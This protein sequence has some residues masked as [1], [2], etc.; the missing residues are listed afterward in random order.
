MPI[1]PGTKLGNYEIVEP[2]GVGGMGEVYRARDTKLGR[3]V[4]IK[5]L[6][7]DVARNTERLSRFEREAKLLAALNHPGIATLYGVEEREGKPFLVM[8]LVDGE[9]LG[10]R[11]VRGRAPVSEAIPQL[12]P[13]SLRS[14]IAISHTPPVSSTVSEDGLLRPSARPD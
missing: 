11:I 13:V 14:N 10:E 4:A 8:E 3:D 7:D 2:I 5:V 12:D 9:T 6:P 1:A